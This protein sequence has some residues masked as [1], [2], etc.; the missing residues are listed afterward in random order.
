MDNRMYG[1]LANLGGTTEL[2]PSAGGSGFW[3]P[4]GRVIRRAAGTGT[5]VLTAAL[6]HDVLDRYA[7]EREA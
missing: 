2:G 4:D 3:G 1:V 5:E 6:Q 7:D